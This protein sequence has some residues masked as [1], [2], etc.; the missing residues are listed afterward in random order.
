MSLRFRLLEPDAQPARVEFSVAVGDEIRLYALDPEL[1][2]V[3][4]RSTV[5]RIGA[6]QPPP[7]STFV[8]VVTVR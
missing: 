7:G 5:A 1:S 8:G 2:W 6:H 3:G 4:L